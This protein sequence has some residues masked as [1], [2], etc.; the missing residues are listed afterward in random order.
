[1]PSRR[2][3]RNKVSPYEDRATTILLR[4]LTFHLTQISSL[5]T[6]KHVRAPF[7]KAER[8]YPKTPS[9]YASQRKKSKNGKFWKLCI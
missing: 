2:M 1:M 6:S 4:G 9:Y 7:P 5:N 8:S 3:L